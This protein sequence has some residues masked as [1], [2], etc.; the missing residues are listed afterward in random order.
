[1]GR[2]RVYASNAERQKAYRE[3][4]KKALEQRTRKLPPEWLRKLQ[5]DVKS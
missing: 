5:E 1:M 4:K 2:T 3:R